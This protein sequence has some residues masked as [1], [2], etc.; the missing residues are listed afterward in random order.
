MPSDDAQFDETDVGP[1]S[2]SSVPRS[3]YD[4]T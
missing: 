2:N 1:S 4:P 3:Y